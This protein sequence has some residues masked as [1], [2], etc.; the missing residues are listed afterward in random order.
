M[1]FRSKEAFN[2]KYNSNRK[3]IGTPVVPEE[4]KNRFRYVDKVTEIDEGVYIIPDIPI[5][6]T[7]DT[8]F[9]YFYTDKGEGMSHDEFDDELF[10]AIVNDNKLSALSSCS[11]RGISNIVDEACRLF[12]LPVNLVTGGFHLK[13]APKDQYSSVL[14][15][16]KLLNPE[17]VGI[18]HC[19][20]VEN[21]AELTKTGRGRVFYNYTGNTEK[22]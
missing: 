15:Y 11:H 22:I 12:Q 19:T 7:E 18:C 16:L 8:S 9:D 6:H 20:G 5:I 4:F 3:F 14:N 1:L 2:K 10:L 13:N 17:N 21:F